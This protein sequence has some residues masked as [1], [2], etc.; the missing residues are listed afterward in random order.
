MPSLQEF[1]DSDWFKERPE[2]IQDL[3]CKLPYAASVRIK[4]TDQKAYVYSW[5][6]NG[7]VRVV[8]DTN[9]NK[10]LKNAMNEPYSVFGYNPED[11]EFICENPNMIIDDGE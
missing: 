5:F 11:L 1:K 3:I 10:H 4:K 6:E 2:V 9:D 8:I 7:T